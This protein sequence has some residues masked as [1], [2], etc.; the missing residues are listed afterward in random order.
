MILFLEVQLNLFYANRSI[1]F[2]LFKKKLSKACKVNPTREITGIKELMNVHDP[3]VKI[4][5]SIKY[6]LEYRSPKKPKIGA[7]AK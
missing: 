4:P 3:Q 7:E 6:F 1:Y 2:Q 5:K